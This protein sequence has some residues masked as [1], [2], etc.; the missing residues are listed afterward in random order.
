[1]KQAPQSATTSA[2]TSQINYRYVLSYK[3]Q[4]ATKN[5]LFKVKLIFILFCSYKIQS[6]T[7][8]KFLKLN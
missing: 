3:I 4:S 5:K 7:E 1:M 2:T 6:T 8:I